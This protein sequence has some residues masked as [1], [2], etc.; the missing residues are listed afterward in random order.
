MAE[1][2]EDW[3]EVAA[4]ALTSPSSEDGAES[5]GSAPVEAAGPTGGSTPGTEV[6]MP[7][8]SPTMSEGTIV[9]W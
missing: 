9:K 1:D 5:A 8:L 3:K 2:G 4:T 7:A 6:K